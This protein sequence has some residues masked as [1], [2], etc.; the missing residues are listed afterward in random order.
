MSSIGTLLLS[1]VV[2]SFSLTSGDNSSHQIREHAQSLKDDFKLSLDKILLSG[3]ETDVYPGTAA[4]VGTLDDSFSYKGSFGSYKWVATHDN[5]DDD[6]ENRRTAI[7]TR[8]DLASVS[9][10]VAGTTAVALLYERGYIELDTLV[11]D[12]LGPEFAQGGK[13]NITIRNCLLHNAGFAPD[14]SPMYWDA[15]FGCPNTL[16]QEYPEEDFSCLS[17]IWSSLFAEEVVTEPGTVFKYS[18]LSFITLASVVGTVVKD[19]SLVSIENLLSDCVDVDTGS[20]MQ[21]LLC[22]YEGFVRTEIFE[23]QPYAPDSDEKLMPST[24]FIVPDEI[25]D[26]CM[27]TINDTV[28]LHKRPQGQ[29]S[30]GNTYAMGG[31]SGHAGVFSNVEDMGR[32]ASNL[33]AAWAESSQ[34]KGLLLLNSTTIRLFGTQYDPL[35]SSRGLGWD[36]NSVEINDYGFSNSCGYFLVVR[37]MA[38]NNKAQTCA[39]NS[40]LVGSFSA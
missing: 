22:Y 8:F 16:T 20:K 19:N 37:P 15:A 12:I 21:S 30:D 29:V 24:S 5:V 27:P 13:E 36:T 14:P 31:I 38:S 10:V 32:L 35:Q 3:I 1:L 23:F 9:K 26:E 18:D 25:R 40:R 17:L 33:V 11:Q 6:V 39:I 2:I 4:L 28:Y 7:D 34:Y